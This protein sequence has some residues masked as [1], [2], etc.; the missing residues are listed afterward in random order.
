[1]RQ[2]E[3]LLNKSVHNQ[4]TEFVLLIVCLLNAH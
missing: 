3:K 1:M 4:W 2:K